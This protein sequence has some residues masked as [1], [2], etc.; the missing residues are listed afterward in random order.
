MEGGVQ[1]ILRKGKTKNTLESSIDSALLA[2]E[3]Y[4]K[5]RAPFR[6]ENYITLMII[7]WTR[8]FHAHFNNTIGNKYYYK[9]RNRYLI[10]DGER[11]AWDLKECMKKY[12]S[13]NIAVCNNLNL[14][15]GLRNKIEHRHIEKETLD[16]LIFGECQAL[17]YNYENTLVDL[18][19]EEYA[20]S[21]NLSFSLQFSKLTT[22]EQK[23]AQRNLL[24]NEVQSLVDYIHKYRSELSEEVFNSQEYSVKIIAIPKVASASRNDV[25]I[26]FLKWESLTEEEMEE[27]QK[28]TTIIKDKVVKVE[29]V[30]I[31]RYRPSRVVELVKESGIDNF[32]MSHHTFLWKHFRVRPEKNAIDPFNTNTL[33]CYYNEAYGDYL[34]TD[35]WVNFIIN[36]I[37]SRKIDLKNLTLVIS[38]DFS[39]YQ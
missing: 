21:E 3:I 37:S 22:K 13:L 10:A 26:N 32:N 2:V 39:Y 12:N 31:R 30:N 20:L 27:V 15:I 34:Y 38:Y 28:L 35:E 24:S 19:G 36:A 4:N 17:L 29:G 9:K 23:K 1:L 11:K 6:V 5:P 14:F 25:A 8:L 33:Y 16:S 7:A 18:F